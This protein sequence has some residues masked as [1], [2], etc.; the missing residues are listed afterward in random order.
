[1]LVTASAIVVGQYKFFN[2]KPFV[3]TWWAFAIVGLAATGI[4]WLAVSVFYGDIVDLQTV[5][6]EYLLT[7][8]LYP[9]VG[10]L[11]ARAQMSL[12][13]DA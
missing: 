9:V 4:R 8:A 3:V 6:V 5:G 1:M 2:G 10:W 7:V 13:K 12:I 11:L